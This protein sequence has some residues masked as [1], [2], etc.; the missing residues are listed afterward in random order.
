[1]NEPNGARDGGDRDNG[2]WS[3]QRRFSGWHVALIVVAAFTVMSVG[4]VIV[5]LIASV[6][7]HGV[8]G[9]NK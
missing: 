2:D 6:L 7:S 8:M 4:V 5:G 1:M 3:G 9:G